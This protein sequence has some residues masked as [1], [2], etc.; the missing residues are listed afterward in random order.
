MEAEIIWLIISNR[1]DLSL[2]FNLY[3]F[4]ARDN[5]A[6]MLFPPLFSFEY[7]SP[8]GTFNIH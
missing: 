7:F 8:I 6:H 3:Q 1:F 5:L 2:W 4:F